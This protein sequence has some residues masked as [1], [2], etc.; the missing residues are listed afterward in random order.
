MR[1]EP[2]PPASDASRSEFHT[3]HPQIA[4]EIEGA[5]ET[6]RKLKEIAT[7]HWAAI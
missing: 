4:D 7:G 5:I 1:R 2:K 3:R 6:L